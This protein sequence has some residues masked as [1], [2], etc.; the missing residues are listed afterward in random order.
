MNGEPA[1]D[2]LRGLPPAAVDRVR[3][4]RESGVRGSLLTAAGAAAVSS[5]GLEPVGEVFGCVVLSLGWF[6][7]TCGYAYGWNRGAGGWAGWS[8]GV[9]GTF[10]GG[11][12]GGT[13]GSP[14]FGT[15]YRMAPPGWQ[16]GYYGNPGWR[17]PVVVSGD[18]SPSRFA[19][20]RPYA[21][22]VGRAWRDAHDR[23][24][25][26]AR[27]LGADGV[28]GIRRRATRVAGG[29]H[30]YA[31]LGTAVRFVEPT[32]NDRVDQPRR[33]P[34]A[35]TLTAED[36]AAAASAGFLPAGVATGY[37]LAIKH[38]DWQLRQQGSSWNNTEV[39]GLTEL[40]SAAR[41]DARHSL[42]GNARQFTS[43]GELVVTDSSLQTGERPCGEEKDLLAEALFVGT[44]LVPHPAPPARRGRTLT[45]LP[46]TPPTA[47]ARRRGR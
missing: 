18:T 46:L 2:D 33:T 28:L 16:G 45:V 30:E 15:G 41:A 36:C 5:I 47:A 29:G 13:S 3:H 12:S 31:S 27:A 32:R 8:G 37:S 19:W 26:E 23:M 35:A 9:P 22:A 39:T 21:E 11:I 10:G 34:W 38:E 7:G 40:L 4:Q 25:T 17:T 6:G 44:V 24:L 14:Q 20:A 42:A 1:E 43:R